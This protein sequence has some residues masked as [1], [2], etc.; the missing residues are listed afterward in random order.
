M[1]FVL[2]AMAYAM[3]CIVVAIVVTAGI[4]DVAA[5]AAVVGGDRRRGLPPT[6]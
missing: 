5:I 2:F 4:V 1:S 6:E 3:M